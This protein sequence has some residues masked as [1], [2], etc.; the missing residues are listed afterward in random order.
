MQGWFGHEFLASWEGAACRQRE[1][2][3][4]ELIE[5]RGVAST[6]RY[7]AA[8]VCSLAVLVASACNQSAPTD[9]SVDASGKIK[10]LVLLGADALKAPFPDVVPANMPLLQGLEKGQM[11]AIKLDRCP[12]DDAFKQ[13]NPLGTLVCGASYSVFWDAAKAAWIATG[14]N[15]ALPDPSAPS[16][17]GPTRALYA[18]TPP[19]S[20]QIVVWGL[21]MKVAPSLEVSIST[22]QVVGTLVHMAPINLPSSQTQAVPATP[23]SK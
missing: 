7:W 15:S 19:S 11:A 4:K 14:P 13:A 22:G 1:Q 5:Q 18:G 16:G 6:Q 21:G 10:P 23:A 2:K 3:M 20:G 9:G 17:F 12:S 8:A